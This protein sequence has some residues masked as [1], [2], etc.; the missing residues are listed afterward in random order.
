M[1]TIV[2]VTPQRLW[3]HFDHV[4]AR[5][6][7]IWVGTFHDVA[8]YVKERDFCT[9]A[10]GASMSGTTV[11]QGLNKKETRDKYGDEQF[12]PWRRS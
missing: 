5:E 2:L 10:H 9:S 11:L 3:D 12:M 4:K 1:V 6:D 7:S 8:A